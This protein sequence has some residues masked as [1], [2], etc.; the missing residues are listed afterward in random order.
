MGK[1]QDF[2]KFVTRSEFKKV[3][4]NLIKL[5]ADFDK[6]KSKIKPVKTREKKKTIEE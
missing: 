1:Q 6:L 2:S 5:Q 4:R 3:E